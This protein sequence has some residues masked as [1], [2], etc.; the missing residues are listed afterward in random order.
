MANVLFDFSN[1]TG[2]IPHGYCI[3]W[4]PDILW[5]SVI[6]DSLIAFAYFSIAA[7]LVFFVLQR[8]NLP[9]CW[10]YLMFG[11]FI[12]ACGTTHLMSIVL[13]WQPVYWLDATI[14]VLTAVMS[15]VTAILLLRLM[16]DAFKLPSHQQLE[17]EIDIRK[18]AQLK[19]EESESRLE[20]L[21]Q[22]LTC[23]VEA[24][25]D[26]IL[27]SDDQGRLLVVN[28][29]AMHLCRL[30]DVDWRG[31]TYRE[32]AV[33]PP[34]RMEKQIKLFSDDENVWTAGHL[35]MFE[36]E[37]IN[38]EGR[39]IE[40]EVRKT[41]IFHETG[42]RKGMV[43]LCRDISD[44]KRAEKE[45]RIA[46]TAIES[47]EGVI[48]TDEN[49]IILRVNRA[50]TRLTGYLPEE[51]I[52][53]KPSILKSGR[54]DAA[55]YRVMWNTLD[56][57]KFW[58]GEVWDRRKNGEIYPKWLTINAVCD[59]NGRVSNYVAAFTDLSQH[60]EAQ[61]A[62]HR[63]AYYDP[64]TDL[65]NRRLL[66]ERLRQA[67]GNSIITHQYGAVL[68]SDLDHFKTINDTMGHQFGD[69]VLIEMAARLKTCLRQGD[70][71]G[72]LGGD[73]F[74]VLLENLGGEE[75][76]ASANA[77]E[78]GQK[79]LQ[80]LNPPLFIANQERFCSTSIGVSLFHE[81]D[82]S[83][84]DI[85][86]RADA[87][88]YQAKDAGRAT[89]RFYN[90]EM[91]ASLESR[92]LLEFELHHALEQDQLLLYYQAQV[93]YSGNIFGAEVLL[94]WIHPLRGEVSPVEFIPIAEESGLILPIG[95][96][97]LQTA[98]E[99]LKTWEKNPLTKCLHLA[100]NISARQFCQCDFVEQVAEILHVTGVDSTKLKLELT[101]TLVLHNVTDTI[102]KMHALKK[103]GVRFS[104]D[105]FGTG[106]SSLAY[107]KKLPL[108]QLKIDRS[109]V[110][111]ILI[112]PSDAIIAQ[113]IIGMG[114]NLGLNVI[115]EG[116]E[117]EEQRA[118]LEGIGCEAFQGYLFN[119][120]M[121]LSQFEQFVARN[122]AA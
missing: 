98:C 46:E 31:Q 10:I 71:V 69:Q 63:L 62:I 89:L 7:I 75:N 64:L 52:G 57:E 37:T 81:S 13:L 120:P 15:V 67:L 88:L 38:D 56:R 90:P 94:R 117:T 27:F 95:Q 82:N 108:S 105:D 30:H 26:A 121:P 33:W 43:I 6:S 19:L 39:C 41:P 91:Q 79:I 74:I 119:K 47:Q 16:P 42:Q 70:I 45:L 93:D 54:H 59:A 102:E 17:T 78:V 66:Q 106:Y 23:L 103:T 72:R 107:L 73:E 50:F 21:S 20:A 14:K 28:E 61:E 118:C 84:D 97:V 92:M 12:L 114:H 110:R 40:V 9:F 55:F 4:S 122:V 24:I 53:Q 100:V 80:A 34:D 11:A 49:N 51:V 44:I 116:V 109:F 87:A 32:S 76:Q 22:Q 113:T 2:L 96:W 60:K 48:V 65:P 25:P 3:K 99:Q 111:D 36:D 68:M 83:F 85:L 29:H 77:E 35:I 115:A 8:K 112:D 5:T 86:K 104:M 1:L 18:T 101:E 58:Q